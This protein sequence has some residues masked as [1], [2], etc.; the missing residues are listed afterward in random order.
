M[1][2]VNSA[3]Q[4][5]KGLA[6]S[7]Q[8][9]NQQAV[10]EYTPVVENILRTRS[11]N[12]KHI[13]HTLNGLSASVATSPRSFCSN[14]SAATTG[15]WTPS[16]PPAAVNAYR[17]MWDSKKPR[18]AKAAP[19]GRKEAAHELPALPELQGQRRGVAGGGAGALG[20]DDR[21][22]AEL[23]PSKS[24]ISA[25]DRDTA[26]SFLPMEAIGDDGTLNLDKEK[27]I[28]EVESR[29]YLLPRW[30]CHGCEDHALL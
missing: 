9:L 3:F 15:R 1:T 18:K 2:N 20:V 5:I 28:S 25:L 22:V 17:E 23:N 13:E 19:P 26:V 24:E 14:N 4:S 30:R 29:I 12:T 6:E 16:P 7:I 21:F 8:S 11:H 27:T 10:R